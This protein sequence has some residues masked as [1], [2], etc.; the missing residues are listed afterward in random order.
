[1]RKTI[2][3]TLSVICCTILATGCSKFNKLLKSNDYETIYASAFKYYDEGK[4]K[5]AL[6]CFEQVEEPF[7]GTMREDSI[8]YYIAR[9]YFKQND[10]SSR[11]ELFYEFRRK[12]CRSPFLEDVEGLY[13]LSYYYLSPEPSRD[14]AMTEQALGAIQEFIGRYPNSTRRAAFE[15]MVKDLT[16]KLYDKVYLN[17]KTYYTIRQYK[18]AV[19]AL[20][21]ALKKYPDSNHREELMYLIVKASY[22]LADNSIESLQRDRFLNMMDSY[23]SFIAEYPDSQYRPELDKLQEDA[24]NYMARFETENPE[25]QA[26]TATPAIPGGNPLQQN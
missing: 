6:T 8:E 2:L 17:A 12:Y 15:Q 10:F 21:N 22:E 26:D 13:A 24:K 9:I 7:R 5:R 20:K 19:P 18:S 11:S 25:Q 16:Q 3:L 1:M 14:Q 4:L 23:Y